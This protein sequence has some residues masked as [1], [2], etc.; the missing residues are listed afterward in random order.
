M[1]SKNIRK[2]AVTAILSAAAFI[3]MFLEFP[4]PMLIPPFIKFDF[5]DLPALIAAF[6][7]GPLSGVAVCFF[8]NALSLA[9][10]NTMMVGEIS[11]FVLGS[12]FV[13]PAG[14]IYKRYH[15]K[16]GAIIGSFVGALAMAIVSFPSNLLVIYPVY[17]NFMPEETI[18]AAY[19]AIF[20]KV[21]TIAECLL[22]FN[23]PFTFAK[24][25]ASCVIT[26]LIYKHISHL[27]KGKK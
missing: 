15:N 4:L 16:K 8:K 14:L 17:Y 20:S 27:L 19:Q 22:L 21:D 23:V 24:G 9:T 26:I 3:L 10:S 12:A 5:S 2:I 13:I 1:H 11:N 25:V 7:F 18:L 6:A